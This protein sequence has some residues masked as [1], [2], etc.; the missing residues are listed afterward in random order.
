MP[1][2]IQTF[3]CEAG[4]EESV[5]C[6][7]TQSEKENNF[8]LVFLDDVGTHGSIQ[9][10]KEDAADLRALLDRYLKE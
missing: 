1:Q 2:F 8:Q 3:N 4:T 9:L 10:S 6:Y 7:L 5:V